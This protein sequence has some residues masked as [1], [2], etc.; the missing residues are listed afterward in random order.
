MNIEE[1]SKYVIDNMSR[2]T[3]V[4][5]LNVSNKLINGAYDVNDFIDTSLEYISTLLSYGKI[6]SEKASRLSVA[7]FNCKRD[8]N[9]DFN[10][11]KTM[12]LN[13]LII[14]VWEICC[15]VE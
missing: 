8:Y 12:I 15:G 14:N 6:S 9:S 2:A 13:D 5:A 10:Y 1:F 7:F 4:N 11:S 3:L